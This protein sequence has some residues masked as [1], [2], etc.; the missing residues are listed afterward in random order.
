MEQEKQRTWLASPTKCQPYR[1]PPLVLLLCKMVA[2]LAK[3]RP[4]AAFNKA[5]EL[6]QDSLY[7]K[8]MRPNNYGECKFLCTQGLVSDR[9][10]SRLSGVRNANTFFG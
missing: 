4:G 9:R 10:K 5:E 3:P 6:F 7:S 2:N 1:L 8:I